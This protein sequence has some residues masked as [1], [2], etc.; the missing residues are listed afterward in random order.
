MK[1][2]GEAKRA[3]HH[4]TRGQRACFARVGAGDDGGAHELVPHK[5]C[6][7]CPQTRGDAV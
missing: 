2:A 1:G 7:I 5:T 4:L 3:N 6:E